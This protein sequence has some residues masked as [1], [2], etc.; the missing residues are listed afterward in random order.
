MILL[1]I[2][3]ITDWISAIAAAIG[4]PL[5]I[6]GFVKLVIRDKEREAQIQSLSSIAEQ[7]TE[8]VQQLS[9][10]TSEFKYQSS[11]M[12][13]QNKLIEKQLELNTDIFL[14]SKDAVEKKQALERQKRI[15]DIKPHFVFAHGGRMMDKVNLTLRNKG[16]KAENISVEFM[17]PTE[18]TLAP[19]HKEIDANTEF[20]INMFIPEGGNSYMYPNTALQYDINLNYNDIDGNRYS[21]NFKMQNHNYQFGNPVLLD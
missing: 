6:W 3:T 10:Q 20:T 21:Q 1:D 8:Q 17:T 13:E 16:S 7:L 4:V 18:L 19:H 2:P 9:T 14:Q 5:A 12:F 11:L 15:N